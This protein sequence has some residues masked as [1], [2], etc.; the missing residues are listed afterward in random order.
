MSL[1]LESVV[2][3]QKKTF[4]QILLKNYIDLFGKRFAKNFQN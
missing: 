2:K 3:N 1:N 4:G